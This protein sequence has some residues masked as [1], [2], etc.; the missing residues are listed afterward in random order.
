MYLDSRTTT[1][2]TIRAETFY[3]ARLRGVDV[4]VGDNPNVSAV[5]MSSAQLASIEDVRVSGTSFHAGFNGLPGS[6]GFSANLEVVGGDYGVVQNQ[7]RPNPSI[8]GLRLV[9][10]RLAGVVVDVS[11]G[12]VVISGFTI[13]GPSRPSAEQATT[14]RAV[15]LRNS[16]A[17]QDNSFNG[18]DGSII[19]HGPSGGGT[20]IETMGGDVVLRNVFVRG[21]ETIATSTQTGMSLPSGGGSVVVRVPA[22]VLTASGGQ[23]LDHGKV[24]TYGKNGSAAWL[25]APLE[26]G[27]QAPW[28]NDSLP[29]LHSWNYS[30]LPAWDAQDAAVL[31]V[32][33]DYGATPQWVDA[34]DDDG[35]KIQ[36]AIDDA[37]NPSSPHH[38]RTVFVPHGEYGVAQPLD[39]RGGCAQ[40]I[41]AGTH[42]TV[43]ATLRETSES[44]GCW[45]DAGTSGAILRSLPPPT[46]SGSGARTPAGLALVSDFGL[47]S[48]HFCPL[49]DLGAGNLL[50]RDVGTRG[51]SSKSSL[52]PPLRPSA[53]APAAAAAAAAAAVATPPPAESCRDEPYVALRNGVSGRFYGLALDGLDLRPCASSPHH[54]LL[55]VEG[56]QQGGGAIHIYQASTE[57]LIN[58]YQ[59]LINETHCG[60]HFHSWKYESALNSVSSNPPSGSGSLVKVR[61]SSSVSVFGSSGN[62]HLF[63]ASVPIIDV[64]ESSNVSLM[65]MTRS[66]SD[67]EPKAGIRWLA[68]S[69]STPPAMMSGYGALLAYNDTTRGRP[70]VDDDAALAGLKYNAWFGTHGSSG[71]FLGNATDAAAAGYRHFAGGEIAMTATLDMIPGGPW[72]NSTELEAVARARAALE[73]DS[74]AAHSAGLEYWATYEALSF[75]RRLV[76]AYSSQMVDPAQAKCIGYRKSH[77]GCISFN[78]TFTRTAFTALLDEVFARYPHIDGLVVRYGE[79]SPAP[80]DVGNAPWNPAHPFTSI[81]AFIGT[82]REELCVRRNKVRRDGERLRE[83]KREKR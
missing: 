72:Y 9:G 26:H 17:I 14:Y 46:D 3:L 19:L 45:P 5:S 42:S 30:Q 82:L 77:H 31:N 48:Y 62:Y 47:A 57:H 78:R 74:A 33:T 39:L 56:C 60:V 73:A 18:E 63:N 1:T 8:T 36:Q 61:G 23:V 41:G 11:R 51:G 21:A 27:V 12:P 55:L 38:G 29:L 83:A 65:G 13:Q 10:Q 66:A 44:G 32:I 37:C 50:L 35:A 64:A 22:Y 68:D 24:P 4:H 15:L 67:H 75:P 2:D 34:T 16:S 58:D 52:G 69:G 40:L 20:A 80:F 28:P 54:V 6:G 53:T 59:N 43:L 79:N 71:A 76:D 25:A 81:A 70:A 49:L 7:Y